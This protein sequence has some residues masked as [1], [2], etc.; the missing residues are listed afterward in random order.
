MSQP[1]NVSPQYNINASHQE[2]TLRD[3]W[4]VAVRRKWLIIAAAVATLLPGAFRIASV[5]LHIPMP[6]INW[7]GIEGRIEHFNSHRIH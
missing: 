4:S 2:S 1:F 7:W 3:Y 5:E 6:S